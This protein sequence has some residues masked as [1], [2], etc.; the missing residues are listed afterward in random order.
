MT[1]R[2]QDFEMNAGDAI[3]IEDT[4]YSGGGGTRDISDYEGQFTLSRYAGGEPLV[5][6]DSSDSR[7][8]FTRPSDGVLEVSLEPADTEGLGREEGDEHYYEIELE[9]ENG[10]PVTVTTGHITI[11]ASY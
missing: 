1:E 8:E 3:T 6:I 11:Y 5:E 9:D 2:H 4:V 10:K 7:F